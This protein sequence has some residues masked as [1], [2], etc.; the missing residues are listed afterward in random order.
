MTVKCAVMNLPYSARLASA[1]E[2][3]G[4][5]PFLHELRPRRHRR[6][7][8]RWCRERLVR[9]HPGSPCAA[10]ARREPGCRRGQRWLP[11]SRRATPS[12]SSGRACRW[13]R[14]DPCSPPTTARR[15]AA[16][17]STP[18]RAPRWSRWWTA[19]SS[20]RRACHPRRPAAPRSAACACSARRAWAPC[21]RRT[22]LSSAPSRASAACSGCSAAAAPGPT[23]SPSCTR[24]TTSG[25]S[26]CPSWTSSAGSTT[27][28]P[29][30]EFRPAMRKPCSPHC[31]PCR[32][33]TARPRRWHAC[34]A[35]T[36]VLPRRG[37]TIRPSPAQRRRTQG[38]CSGSC[39][40]CSAAPPASPQTLPVAPGTR[41]HRGTY[42]PAS[43]S[44]RGTAPPSRQATSD[45]IATRAFR[46]SPR[47]SDRVGS[48]CL[49]ARFLRQAGGCSGTQDTWPPPASGGGGTSR[50][51][52][53]GDGFQ[54][55]GAGGSKAR[56]AGCPRPPRRK[57]W[58][59]RTAFLPPTSSSTWRPAT[60]ATLLQAL[61][62]EAASRLGRPEGEILGALQARERLGSTALGRGVAL[63][64]ARLAGDDPPVV[65]FAR[66][67]RPIDY[68]A[69]D[70]EPVDLVILILWPE[71]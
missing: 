59:S 65:L 44:C 23:T 17:T 52:P 25:R 28:W 29:P 10:V 4:T 11:A 71:A 9:S 37:W 51:A 1:I 61:A 57:G 42:A 26:P 43:A 49:R 54:Q 35:T 55:A 7:D 60:S 39:S 14:R 40:G 21:S 2:A 62:A 53:R 27:R 38:G 47:Q 24:R 48:R 56:E 13:R 69:R 6:E 32:S 16:A 66:L 33:R 63:P 68:E 18:S 15:S 8:T 41:T 45:R 64:H 5:Q 36:W 19:S 3:H 30:G 46:Q 50:A 70:E 34:Y 58:G 20:P 12:C 22:R 67:R 31:A